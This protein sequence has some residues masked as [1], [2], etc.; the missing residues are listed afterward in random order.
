MT[1]NFN[2]ASIARNLVRALALHNIES[3][4]IS[5]IENKAESY[6]SETDLKFISKIHEGQSTDNAIYYVEEITNKKSSFYFAGSLIEAF[7]YVF[8]E[9]DETGTHTRVE[10][11]YSNDV[12]DFIDAGSEIEFYEHSKEDDHLILHKRTLRKDVIF[13][14]GEVRTLALEDSDRKEFIEAL[15]G[16]RLFD[17][18]GKLNAR[19]KKI[20]GFNEITVNH[21]NEVHRPSPALVTMVENFPGFMRSFLNDEYG[22]ELKLSKILEITA[23]TFG[24]KDWNTFK[25]LANKYRCSINKPFIRE[26]VQSNGERKLFFFDDVIDSL[27]FLKALK[28][29]RLNTSQFLSNITLID[30]FTLEFEFG[31]TEHKKTNWRYLSSISAMQEIPMNWPIPSSI[32]AMSQDDEYEAVEDMNKLFG[33]RKTPP[34]INEGIRDRVEE[35]HRLARQIALF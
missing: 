32:L 2:H 15:K 19:L 18:S 28:N 10:Y 23:V 26:M 13:R 22:I 27:Y 35:R 29:N 6:F 14:V 4:D 1:S 21:S 34:E 11:D 20:D 16:I 7:A 31:S 33:Y 3:P 8:E 25:A 12:F 24:F 9:V 30:N 17:N 5:V